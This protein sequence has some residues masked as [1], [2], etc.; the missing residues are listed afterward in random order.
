MERVD[1]VVAA[2]ADLG[3]GFDGGVSMQPAQSHKPKE[4]CPRFVFEDKVVS[5]GVTADLSFGDVARTLRE[6]VPTRL[7]RTG[8][9]RLYPVEQIFG[10]I[11]CRSAN[12]FNLSKPRERICTVKAWYEKGSRKGVEFV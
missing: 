10:L 6:Q 5:F 12:K 9:H 7:W 11:A 3:S 8:Q 4:H 2:F 1:T